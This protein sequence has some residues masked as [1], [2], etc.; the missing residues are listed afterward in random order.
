M[1]YSADTFVADEQ[2]TTAKW[3]KLWANDAAFN[4]GSGIAAS[5]ILASHRSQVTKV[6]NFSLSATGAKA[7][8]GVG[9][10]PKLVTFDFLQDSSTSRLVAATGATDGT[11][12]YARAGVAT[13]TPNAGGQY[14]TSK[15]LLVVNTTGTVLI[16]ASITSLD[17]DGF[18]LNV[19]TYTN[20][21]GVN[22]GYSVVA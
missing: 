21:Y 6:G 2:P 16:D 13:S 19:S 3:N 14:S 11:K 15:C 10:K 22:F 5:A 12:Q 9:F 18:T 1:A 8:T 20:T 4:D 7:I 17:S